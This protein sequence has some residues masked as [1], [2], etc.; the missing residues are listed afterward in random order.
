[1]K[2]SSP[3]LLRVQ[4]QGGEVGDAELKGFRVEQID[5]KVTLVLKDP[6]IMGELAAKACR[7]YEDP[8]LEIELVTGA[9]KN[10]MTLFQRGLV[11]DQVCIT[12]STA[13]NEARHSS[14]KPIFDAVNCGVPQKVGWLD[15]ELQAT[16]EQAQAK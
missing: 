6:A 3:F 14:F 9:K 10:G 15:T 12:D 4:Q 13:R 7:D 1:M 5:G 11:G 16:C 2:T 8:L